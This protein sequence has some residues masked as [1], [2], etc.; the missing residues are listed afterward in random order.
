MSFKRRGR[1]I[2]EMYRFEL[3]TVSTIRNP[4]SLKFHIFA[5]CH[6]RGG[7]HHG[8]QLP[9][10]RTLTRRTQNPVSSLWKVT[11]ST[12]PENSLVGVPD[13]S[14]IRDTST[15]TSHLTQLACTYV[16]YADRLY[17]FAYESEQRGEMWQRDR[18]DGRCDAGHRGV[19]ITYRTK[20]DMGQDHRDVGY[21][22]DQRHELLLIAR[23]GKPKLP[24]KAVFDV[25]QHLS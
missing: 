9:M 24:E 14:A 13:D 11:R 3:E 21:Y 6:G 1:D 5:W 8:F 25:W 23:Q 19:G 2:A 17:Y 12:E 20:H 18:I 15:K 16:Q 22:T 4:P 10:P 7:S